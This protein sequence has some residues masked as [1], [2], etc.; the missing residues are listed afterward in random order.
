M[1]ERACTELIQR[2][3]LLN[4]WS[5]G[6]DKYHDP[7]INNV[8]QYPT[9]DIHMKDLGLEKMW[10]TFIEKY[11]SKIA[12]F[13]YSNYKTKGLNIAFI[14]KYEENKQTSLDPHHDS[15]TYTVNIALNKDYEGG[16]CKFIRQD[17]VLTNKEI[18]YATIHPGK[19]THYH[20]GLKV[21]KGKRYIL[22]SFIN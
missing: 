6:G 18:G 19:L 16:G 8:E 21:T 1:S 11:I 15:S 5:K 9:Q 17:V 22:V 20:E 7:R 10:K 12:A 2:A 13:K 4:N 14:V 3:E